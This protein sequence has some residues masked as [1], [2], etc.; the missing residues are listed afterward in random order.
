[1]ELLPT[2]GY[3]HEHTNILLV[4]G[5]EPNGGCPTDQLGHGWPHS[6]NDL[7]SQ[8]LM[9]SKQ[10][11]PLFSERIKKWQPADSS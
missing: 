11:S 8:T 2:C 4:R 5:S 6:G 1:M 9:F 7:L 3:T 10:T